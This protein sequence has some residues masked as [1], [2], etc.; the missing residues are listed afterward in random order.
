MDKRSTGNS[1]RPA[2]A[3][4]A[5][6]RAPER[7]R[8]E[9]E[10]R[11]P[12]QARLCGERTAEAAQ[13]SSKTTERRFQG[14]RQDRPAFRKPSYQGGGENR[15]AFRQ[16]KASARTARADRFAKGRIQGDDPRALPP[17]GCCAQAIVPRGGYRQ[18][19]LRD[20]ASARTAPA[21]TTGQSLLTAGMPDLPFSG[22]TR[23][24]RLTAEQSAR[25][26]PAK[27]R[28]GQGESGK[29]AFR[30]EGPGGIIRQAAFRN[31]GFRRDNSDK[32]AFGRVGSTRSIPENP[33]S[34]MG[35]STG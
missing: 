3:K 2:R 25:I 12:P 11:T 34:E 8:T 10:D 18:E 1:G 13:T 24:G 16:K 29:P 33:L 32:P 21:G 35:V 30:N 23:K 20:R 28:R 4:A 17:E 27:R 26:L 6:I 31:E 19:G 9:T 7:R 5:F 15:P 22:T 14:R